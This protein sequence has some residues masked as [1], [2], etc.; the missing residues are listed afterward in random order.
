MALYCATSS[1][2]AAN[3]IH[4]GLAGSLNFVAKAIVFLVLILSAKS[5][6]NHFGL[7]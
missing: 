5:L 2:H 1:F 7:K 3:A 4:P 6:W